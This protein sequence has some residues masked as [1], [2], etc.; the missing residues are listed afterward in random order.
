LYGALVFVK[1]FGA[2][3]RNFGTLCFL[4]NALVLCRTVGAI[5]SGAELL[6]LGGAIVV[7]ESVERVGHVHSMKLC[8]L[9]FSY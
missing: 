8:F 7:S 2:W 6:F 4:W 5:E 1:H 3:R 9:I